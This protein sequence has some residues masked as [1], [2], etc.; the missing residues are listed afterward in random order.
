MVTRKLR[1]YFRGHTIVILT[2]HPL[3]NVLQKHDMS[4][5]LAYIAIELSEF[6][7]HFT[8]ST[9][10]G[11]VVVNFIVDGIEGENQSK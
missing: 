5:R 2:S 4:E 6:D 8:Y 9:I 7:I 3:K 10:K 11:Q 1:C